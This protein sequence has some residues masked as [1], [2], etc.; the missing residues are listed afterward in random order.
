[1]CA[2]VALSATGGA[3]AVAGAELI[4]FSFLSLFDSSFRLD[5]FAGGV[6]LLGLAAVLTGLA[7]NRRMPAAAG[8]GAA[9]LAAA[10]LFSPLVALVLNPIAERLPLSVNARILLTMCA[11]VAISAGAAFVVAE[12]PTSGRLRR[13]A[14]W[15]TAAFGC[16]V[17]LIALRDVLGRLLA[18]G[19]LRQSELSLELAALAF[20]GLT[21][22]A[23]AYAC[24]RF[25]SRERSGSRCAIALVL[26]LG[27][28]AL[29]TALPDVLIPAARGVT[30]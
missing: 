5:L 6:I 27:L 30:P 28:L 24:R 8:A 3:A 7:H 14:G 9:G 12:P 19:P 20:A 29:L 25:V 13:S 15:T 21:S 18:S 2:S 17:V 1:L 11:A 10:G 16:A 4:L 22:A 23:V 26:A